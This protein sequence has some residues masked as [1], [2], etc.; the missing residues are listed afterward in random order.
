LIISFNNYRKRRQYKFLKFYFIAVFLGLIAW[1][2]NLL[3]AL[4]FQWNPSILLEIGV[5]NVIFFLLF[6]YGVIKFTQR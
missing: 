4:F 6:F 5:L 3:V 1:I 2:L